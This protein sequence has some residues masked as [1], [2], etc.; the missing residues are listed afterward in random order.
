[1]RNRGISFILV[2]CLLFSLFWCDPGF[3]SEGQNLTLALRLVLAK[4]QKAIDKKC[5][6]DAEKIITDYLSGRSNKPHYLAYY[7]L[8]NAYYLDKNCLLYTSPSPRD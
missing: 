1:M 8:G 2:V 5:Y 6:Q 4:A 7:I 3:A